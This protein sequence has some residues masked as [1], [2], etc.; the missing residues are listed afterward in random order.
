MNIGTNDLIDSWSTLNVDQKKKIVSSIGYDILNKYQSNI[1]KIEFLVYKKVDSFF[2]ANLA[3]DGKSMSINEEPE[4][5]RVWENPF[6]LIHSIPH[7]LGH[8]YFKK[9]ELFDNNTYFLFANREYA[10]MEI[11][12]DII[13]IS[14]INYY[15]GMDKIKDPLRDEYLDHCLVG[16]IKNY[17]QEY[18]EYLSL[19]AGSKMDEQLGGI[20]KTCKES[21]IDPYLNPIRQKRL[22]IPKKD[23]CYKP[24]KNIS[25]ED[26]PF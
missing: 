26:L 10:D 16:F 3:K 9:V 18:D 12:C 14:I 7:E 17:E 2:R 25:E 13:A 15:F 21:L 22:L 8:A 1:E 5:I 23:Y 6:L 19:L 11:T 4:D 24:N 20:I